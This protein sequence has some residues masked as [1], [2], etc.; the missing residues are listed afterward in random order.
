MEKYANRGEV[1]E[2]YK[3]DL[4]SFF[5]NEE[6]FDKVLV[7]TEKMAD[8]LND[9]VG[10]TRNKEKLLEFIKL[11]LEAEANWEDLYVYA[12]LICDEN[13]GVSSSIERKNKAENLLVKI[14]NAVSFF[15]PEL[16]TLTEDEYNDLFTLDGLKVYKK[17]F[18]YIYRE[19]AHILT[20]NEEIIVNELVNSMNS[21]DD[22]SS[23]LLNNEHDYGKVTLDDGTEEV[24]SP[25]NLFRIC[26][27]GSRELRKNVRKQFF[28]VIDQYSASNA[29]YLNSYVKM[30][31][32]LAKI[33]KYDS[34]WAQKLF[35]LNM[36]DDVFKTL[37]D[38]VESKVDVFQKFYKLKKKAYGLD[39]LHFY[40]LAPDMVKNDKEYSIEEAQDIVKKALQ[41]LGDEYLECINKIF[42]NRYI[43]YCQYKGKASG[44]YSFS[45]SRQDSR[46]L[47]SFN[48]DL[49]S[50]STIIH[51]AGHNVHHQLLKKNNPFFYTNVSSMVCEV[52][53]LTNECLLSSYLAEHGETKEEKL[54]GIENILDV[55]NSNLFGAVREGKMELDFYN[56]VSNGGTI[57]KDYMDNLT[58]ESISKYYG[59]SVIQDN[60]VKNGWVNRSHY[61][62]HFYLFSYAICVCVATYVASSILNG[63]KDMI[64][65]YKE[66]LSTGSD[67]W[68][69]EAFKVLG[70]DLTDKNV[71]LDGIEYFDKMIDKYDSII[72][73]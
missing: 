62:M 19:K 33:R 54:A 61:Y 46:V 65:R 64:E 71:Y 5:K 42:D 48:G 40:D 13:V 70:V 12:Y 2:K 35:Q 34:S 10:C 31:I 55:I 29:M 36:T 68:P 20:E 3:W 57:T 23:N 11:D 4:T 51:E 69:V 7:E 22:M 21:F 38:V 58:K 73:E 43:D 25:T 66:F 9:Y 63:D 32:A 1:P 27:N 6:E 45:T 26:K 50:I 28:D 17:Y 52:A 67:K 41:P 24:L 37:V 8:K 60:F 16:L 14:N 59:D 49:D 30:N 53:S 39:E 47:L 18:D 15:S 44:G 56:H 72:S